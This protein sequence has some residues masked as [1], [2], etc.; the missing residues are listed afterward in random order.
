MDQV[1]VLLVAA[2]RLDLTADE[3]APLVDDL[4]DNFSARIIGTEIRGYGVT[5]WEVLLA[6]IGLKAAD[7]TIDS[8]TQS[9][10]DSV[11]SFV[12]RKRSAEPDRRPRPF[13][14][15]I[16]DEDGNFVKRLEIDSDG[17]VAVLNEP[18]PEENRHKPPPEAV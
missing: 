11:K 18:S 9:L 6:Y 7:T 5:W 15:T 4:S 2:N 13:S 14:F 16:Y 8:V 12:Q 17:E 1:H 3:L 10:I